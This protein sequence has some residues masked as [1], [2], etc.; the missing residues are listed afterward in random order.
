MKI[1]DATA[2]KPVPVGEDSCATQLL[3][4][5]DL[6]AIDRV[7][8]RDLWNKFLN[9][10]GMLAHLFFE[11]LLMIAPEASDQFGAAAW[12]APY[13]YLTFLDLA[14]RSLSPQ[15]ERPLREGYTTAPSARRARCETVADCIAFFR[16][17][18][19]SDE[20]HEKTV[21]AFVWTCNKIPAAESFDRDDL[22]NGAASAA[23]R[24][25]RTYIVAPLLAVKQEK[26]AILSPQ[27][28]GRMTRGAEAM[29][30]RQHEAGSFFYGELFRKYPDAMRHFRTSD[31]DQLSRHL[32]DTVV[33]LSEIAAEPD[34]MRS[35]LTPLATV[36]LNYRIPAA[37]YAKLTQ[38]LLD[39]LETFGAPMG[40]DVRAGWLT[41]FDQAIRIIAEPMVM[42]EWMVGEARKF[43]QQIADELSWSPGQLALRLEEVTREIEV[44]GSYTHTFEELE[45]GAKLAWRNAGK[46]I[47]R[48]SWK[49]LIL[50]DCRH[51][52]DAAA[53]FRESVEHLRAAT[54]GGNVEIV[55]TAFRPQGPKE[56]WGPR[57]W[58]SQLVRYAGYEDAQGSIVGDGENVDLTKAITRLGW[59]PP[60]PRGPYDILPLVIEMPG[61]APQI[62]EIDRNEVLE[63]EITHPTEPAIA[64]LGMKWCAVPAITNFNLELGGLRYSCVP[65]NGWFM[66]TEIA[67]DLWEENRYDRARDIADVLGLDTSSEA[68]LWRDRAF[69]ELNV[70][71]LHSFQQAKVTLVDHHT[72]SR[73]FLYHDLREKKAGR[74]CPAQWSWIAP[75]AGGSTTPVWHHE[76]RDFQLAPSF[77]YE[78]NRWMAFQEQTGQGCPMKSE[79]RTLPPPRNQRPLILFASETGTAEGYARQVGR[80]L[81]HLGSDIRAMDDVSIERLRGEGRILFVVATCR[82]GEIPEHG[83]RFLDKLRGAGLA[84]DGIRY[85]VLGLG[86]RIYPK[87][88]A[89]A[90]EVNS[91][92]R[93]AGGERLAA[94]E[95][96]DE[97]AGQGET[98]RGW[99]DIFAKM[100]SIDGPAARPK[101][102]L[103]ELVPP[104]TR[105]PVPSGELGVIRTNEELLDQSDGRV[106]SELRSTRRIAIDLPPCPDAG[107]APR[108]APGD[109]VAIHPVNPAD[110]VRRVARHL[111]LPLDAWF[112]LHGSLDATDE[113]YRE[114][115]PLE[116]LLAETLD[117]GLPDAPEEL[118]GAMA[119]CS[120]DAE[121]RAA[122]KE[123]LARLGGEDGGADRQEA[124]T[125]LRLRY[126]TVADVFDAF[127]HSVPG[128]EILIDLLPRLKPR[129]YSVASSPLSS[130]N[131]VEILAGVLRRRQSDGRIV[132]GVASTYLAGLQSGAQVRIALKPSPHRLPERG[133]TPLLL[134]AAGTG[135]APL[136]GILQ[137]RAA[138]SLAASSDAPVSLYFGC[139][140]AGEFLYREEIL[141]WLER[142]LL[143]RVMT[144][145]SRETASK[146]YVQD[147]LDADGAHVWASLQAA[148]TRVMIAGDARMA[149]EVTERLG[150][151]A[152][153]EGGMT[154]SQ[155]REF[156]ERLRAEGRLIEDIWGIQLNHSLSVSEMLDEKYNSGAKWFARLQRA[157]SRKPISSIAIRRY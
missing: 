9:H 153:R 88:C 140:S 128:L 75:S 29:I 3:P 14:A 12:R 150:V 73:Q 127:S 93:A 65:F 81:A 86:N 13:V 131:R 15:T 21:E 117:L 91:A 120:R 113:P 8:V 137:D 156:M 138:R 122:L 94:V 80:R 139:R 155:S 154:V 95:C 145:F 103:V 124:L 76:M 143:S 132:N 147:A 25:F 87:F 109:Y 22:Q 61:E 146:A 18:D 116:R 98:V 136:L 64:E 35:E 11:R 148:E 108:Y 89:A 121:D 74:E 46:C 49:N 107:E 144:A 27:V 119:A 77:E 72:A 85:A 105:E 20:V 151:I 1:F 125:T 39:T 53:I 66:G 57:I 51:A 90:F 123:L 70:A 78:A 45:Y 6:T 17:L 44:T 135:I 23:A 33:L 110:L 26:K 38:P 106:A 47:G 40:E 118:L 111:E 97:I 152:R 50:R 133:E 102:K 84:M 19:L 32:I 41:L 16:A 10:D 149:R 134:V 92:I 79:G 83:R 126:H 69:L 96:A 71:I 42:H 104:R 36:H 48:I 100:W 52:T 58:N 68:T 82:D 63:V 60:E 4:A 67:R 54:N 99:A 62:F 2:F 157:F 5:S 101:R 43:L 129:Y 142:G 34:R 59:R 30:G 115:Y 130:P 31:M 37:D 7:R 28:V 56:R 141:A 55:L 112:A 24:F 114:A